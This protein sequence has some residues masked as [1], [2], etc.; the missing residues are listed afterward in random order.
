V[1]TQHARPGGSGNSNNNGTDN[2]DNTHDF[3][4]AFDGERLE[5][6]KGGVGYLDVATEIGV[7]VCVLREKWTTPS[8]RAPFRLRN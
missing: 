7:L 2:N 1:K 5:E 8:R 4:A 6:L 3:K